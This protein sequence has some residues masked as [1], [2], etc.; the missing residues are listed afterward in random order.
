[1]QGVAQLNLFD[2]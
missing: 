2:D 1:C